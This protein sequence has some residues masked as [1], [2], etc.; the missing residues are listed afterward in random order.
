MACL[1]LATQEQQRVIQQL[2]EQLTGLAVQLRAAYLPED[3]YIKAFA[4][5]E[6]ID[7]ESVVRETHMTR[8]TPKRR[9]QIADTVTDILKS[10][11]AT[12]VLEGSTFHGDTAKQTLTKA[13]ILRILNEDADTDPD[14]DMIFS[15]S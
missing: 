9:R 15:L 5:L 14:D 7:S 10:E 8:R 2:E 3:L 13:E 6:V 4:A 1:S 11:L 12:P